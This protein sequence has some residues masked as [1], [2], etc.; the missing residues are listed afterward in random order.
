MGQ[1]KITIT[2]LL[3]KKKEK[4]PITMLTAYD[5]PLASIIDEAGIDIILVGDSVAMVVLGYEN[6]LSVTI[7]NM[8]YHCKA[9]ARAVRYAFVI[10]DMPFKSY[11]TPEEAVTNA[12]RFIK[13]GSCQAVKLEGG[14]EVIEQVR[15]II[16]AKIPVL[17]H[18][19]LTPQSAAQAGGG[20][21]VQGKTAISAKKIIDDAVKLQDA[22]CFAIVL[23]CIPAEISKIITAKIK[24]PI[25][26]I[27]A[28][29]HCDG[30]VLVTYD[31]L[32]LYKKFTPKFVKRYADI[33][34][35]IKETVL[36]YKKDVEERKFPAQ[37]HSFSIVEEELHKLKM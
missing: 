19:G 7:D 1:H 29:I 26:G 17:G 18:I 31:I 5:F 33:S 10:G 27:G 28:G 2:D 35:Q 14:V 30:Q 11:Q 25:I 13:E 15:A 8:L 22:G 20:F 32:G 3:N 37:E 9:V 16:K 36:Q 6:T 34:R 12:T 21:K 4:N 24:I 23:E